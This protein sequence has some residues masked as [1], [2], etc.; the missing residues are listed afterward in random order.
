MDLKNKSQKT[1]IQQFYEGKVVLLTGGTGFLG[2]VLIEKLLR[3]CPNI[4]QL[5]LLVREKNSQSS[6]DRLKVL[7]E[8]PIFSRLKR[9][10]PRFAEKLSVVHGELHEPMLGLSESHITLLSQSVD[11][12]LHSAASVRFNEHL[13]DAI[14]TNVYGTKQLCLLAQNMV[15]LKALVYVSTAFSNCDSSIIPEEICPSSICP[16]ILIVLSELLDKRLLDDITPS[17]LG[18][19]PNTYIYT[20]NAAEVVIKRFRTTLPVAILRPSI[21]VAALSE[22]FPGWLDN[23]QGANYVVASFSTGLLRSFLSNQYAVANLV[24]VDYT[25]NAILALAFSVATQQWQTPQDE[26]IPVVNFVPTKNNTMTWCDFTEKLV[27]YVR[28]YPS[29]NLMWYPFLCQ[30]QSV[31]VASVQNMLLHHLPAKVI[32]FLSKQCGHS[33]R[34][35]HI[36]NRLDKYSDVVRYFSCQHF[37]FQE[38]NQKLLWE[39]LEPR[40]QLEFPFNMTEISWEIVMAEYVRGCREYYLREQPTSVVRGRQRLRRLYFIHLLTN[41]SLLLASANIIWFMCGCLGQL[42]RKW[43]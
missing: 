24:P 23:V 15:K 26:E 6:E 27:K 9:E 5:Y 22:P 39:S 7:L 2:K 10:N 20:K 25:A 41:T 35:Q 42:A 17:L 29:T 21:V 16:D 8:D 40:D 12:V 34:L 33:T 13:S 38:D 37:Q 32:D 4:A 18:S 30:P 14:I 19:K 28:M 36:Y 3:S 31:C 11:V 1:K 43:V